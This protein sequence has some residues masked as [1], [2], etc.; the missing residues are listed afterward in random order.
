MFVFFVSALNDDNCKLYQYRISDLVKI[1]EC[2]SGQLVQLLGISLHVVEQR[3]VVSKFKFWINFKSFHWRWD[4]H[5]VRSFHNYHQNGL[6]VYYNAKSIHPHQ[7]IH[8]E[9]CHQ[10]A[11]KTFFAHLC[12]RCPYCKTLCCPLSPSELCTRLGNCQVFKEGFLAIIK[13]MILV[14]K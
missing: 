2:I 14:R 6:I 9:I 3:W 5:F 1:R 4:K 10:K 8:N 7:N 12:R 13:I 11:T